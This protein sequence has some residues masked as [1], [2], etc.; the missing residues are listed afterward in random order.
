MDGWMDGWVNGRA[1]IQTGSR[2]VYCRHRISQLDPNLGP[3]VSV[4]VFATYL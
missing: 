2:E 3:L 4:H 1:G